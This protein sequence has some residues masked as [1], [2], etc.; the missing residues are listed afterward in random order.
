MQQLKLTTTKENND[1]LLFWKT[2]F[3][4]IKSEEELNHLFSGI[5][6]KDL[7]YYLHIRELEEEKQKDYIEKIIS[8]NELDGHDAFFKEIKKRYHKDYKWIG[9]FKPLLLKYDDLIRKVVFECRIVKNKKDLIDSIYHQIL[10][11]MINKS[12]RVI[13]L[14]V[15]LARE[16]ELLKGKTPEERYNYFFEELVVD[17]LF[18]KSLYGKYPELIRALDQ[19]L[20][21]TVNYINE[22]LDNTVTE[23]K[24]LVK[25]MN[26]K[27]ELILKNIEFSHGDSHNNNK[28]VA[29]LKFENDLCLMYKPRTLENEEAYEK[30]IHWLDKEM[31]EFKAPYAARV[32]TKNN[33]GYMEFISRKECSSEKSIN[34]FYYKMG[35]LVAILYS[36]NSKDFHGENIIAYD[37]D[38]VLIDLETLLHKVEMVDR[39]K[40]SSYE[41]TLTSIINSVATISILPTTIINRQENLV[42]EVGAMNSG[43]SRKSPYKTQELKGRNTDSIRIENVY[44]EIDVIDSSPKY[45]GAYIS[46][47]NYITDIKKGFIET[48]KWIEENRERYYTKIEALFGQYKSRYIYR[49]TNNYT[50]LIETS[51]HPDL[52]HNKID[53]YIYLHRVFMITDYKNNKTFTDICKLEVQEMINGDI[54]MYN[55]KNNS[56]VI[57][58][59]HN[60]TV[61]NES[62]C[63]ILQSIKER[64]G[65][66]SEKDLRRQVSLINQCFMGSG[67]RTDIP[68]RTSTSYEE[69]GVRSSI[70][71]FKNM[72]IAKNLT[73][74]M[75]DRSIRNKYKNSINWIGMKGYGNKYYENL[76]V[77]GDLYQG[78]GGISITLIGMYV[79]TKDEKYR[80]SAIESVNYIIEYLRE[81]PLIN[82]SLGSF[83][84]L[85]G[86]LYSLGLA[87]EAGIVSEKKQVLDLITK[88]IT[89][90]ESELTDLNDLDIISGLAGILGT[91]L[92]LKRIIVKEVPE[93]DFTISRIIEVVYN[94]LENNAIYVDKDT[95]K[96]NDN[97]DSGYAH[98]SAGIIT[99]IMRYY[100]ED[101]DEKKL[102]LVRK[103]LNYERKYL[104]DEK[105][106]TWRTRDNSHY[107]S[108]CNGIGGILLSKLYL[109]NNGY[110]DEKITF[111]VEELIKQLKQYGFGYDKSI[112]HGDLGSLILLEYAGSYYNDVTMVNTSKNLVYDVSYK[113]NNFKKEI[114]FEIED[115]G[116]MTGTSGVILS[117]LSNAGIVD[118]IKLFLLDN[119]NIGG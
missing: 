52:L 41:N 4:E 1:V 51:Y 35:E 83:S 59:M 24:E 30:L 66:F 115:W 112:C 18:Q 8:F 29:K 113:H 34:N 7:D 25:K 50:Q 3:P 16:N 36:L 118:A 110:F 119:P 95:V 72:E 89:E 60:D 32:H 39:K 23:K 75:L 37:E 45:K 109:L 55:I 61:M 94:R 111:E 47:D 12:F 65:K 17:D 71:I 56:T 67:L 97:F 15:N 19:Y 33:F 91:L 88:N 69:N 82:M 98:G 103:S 100:N 74:I 26:I 49:S 20:N 6:N 80:I 62:G 14:E 86:I 9:F 101:G 92:T 42:M 11:T 93:Y 48:Y 2:L 70:D 44:K 90:S 58:N 53:R 28:T 117:L 99:Q 63:S 31:P 64:L 27:K 114:S 43:K 85:Y 106:V 107:F 10:Q 5:Y 84:G 77:E 76:P 54:P 96:W 81:T 46:A 21:N 116:L 40:I 73:N 108:W 78:N 104:F 79:A 102:D 87:L 57:S 68:E 105:E 13:V 38:P 22:I